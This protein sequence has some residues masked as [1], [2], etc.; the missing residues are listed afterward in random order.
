[1]SSALTDIYSGNVSPTAK[2]IYL[3]F[4][5]NVPA[6]LQEEFHDL[7]R[8]L[9]GGPLAN[10]DVNVPD[11]HG[12]NRLSATPITLGIGVPGVMDHPSDTDYFSFF[13][14]GDK[15]YDAILENDNVRSL[16]RSL[17]RPA[18]GAGEP[19]RALLGNRGTTGVRIGWHAEAS[20][21]YYLTVE[22]LSATIPCGSF[23]GSLT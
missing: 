13:A 17:Y 23:R 6:G 22:R 16:K 12:D 20:G 8:Q 14:E 4:Q 9:Y 11:D 2:D 5:R 3:A 18:G 21:Q 19:L 7:F 1:M 10:G 15:Q